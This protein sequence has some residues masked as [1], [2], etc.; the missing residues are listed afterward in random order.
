[1][2]KKDPLT[3]HSLTIESTLIGIDASCKVKKKLS[4]KFI[5]FNKFNKKT[6]N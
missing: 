6:E 4:L 1:M 2:K 5:K 3:I